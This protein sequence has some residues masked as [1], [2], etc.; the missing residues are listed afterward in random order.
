MSSAINGQSENGIPTKLLEKTEESGRDPSIATMHWSADPN[1]ILEQM[2]SQMP[3][4]KSPA[5]MEIQKPTTIEDLRQQLK[6][7][8]E[9]STEMMTSWQVKQLSAI[10]QTWTQ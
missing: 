1:L 4:R 7:M 2:M 10:F 9:S 5:F 3:R 6:F 8:A